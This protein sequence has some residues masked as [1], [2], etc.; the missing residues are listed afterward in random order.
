M[1]TKTASKQAAKKKPPPKPYHHGDLRQEILCAACDLLEQETIASLSFRQVAKKVGVSHTAPYRHFKDK[2]SLLASIAGVGFQQLSTRLI[3]AVAAN[4]N[5]PA[6]QLKAAAHGYVK[7]A[8]SHPQCTQLM[9]GGIL[10]CDDTYPDVVDSGDS[11]FAGLKTIIQQGQANGVFKQGDIETLAL[12][13]WSS[14]HGLALLLI[15]GNLPQSLSITVDTEK[16]T[17]A[18]TTTLL[19]GLISS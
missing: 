9:F 17:D 11:A 7:M 19:E 6:A 16:L 15:G 3:E 12:T 2:E 1:T 14:I 5:D 8:M 13:A 10:P 4:I 18:L